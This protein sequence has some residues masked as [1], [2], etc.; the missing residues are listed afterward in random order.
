VEYVN[1]RGP[2]EWCRLRPLYVATTGKWELVTLRDSK[3][4]FPKE[5]KLYWPRS[6]LARK[7]SA[8]VVT[9][10]LNAYADADEKP[11]R[12]IVESGHP[13]P[14]FVKRGTPS[15]DVALRRSIANGSLTFPTSLPGPV[16]VRVPS[17]A[18]Q[19]IG[20]LNVE[21]EPSGDGLYHTARV[22]AEGFIDVHEMTEAGLQ[23]IEFGKHDV[24]T[25]APK[26]VIGASVDAFNI[27]SDE[28]LLDG[29]L[30]RIRKLDPRAAEGLKVTKAVFSKYLE[31]LQNADLVGDQAQSEA[32]RAHAMKLLVTQIDDRLEMA[33]TTVEALSSLPSVV[34]RT[35]IA[36]QERVEQEA[37]R[38]RHDAEIRE[39]TAL[40]R[41]VQAE[42][43]LAGL[44]QQRVVVESEATTLAATVETLKR[45]LDQLPLQFEAAM[46]N[47]A[48]TFKSDPATFLGQSIF[49]RF[50][51]KAFESTANAPR[52]STS[53]IP[54]PLRADMEL[55]TAKDLSTSC[56]MHARMLGLD[57]ET[58][59]VAATLVTNARLVL[60]TGP[61]V[62]AVLL[63][64][65]GSISGGNIL[66]FSVPSSVFGTSDIL[67]L[68]A[69]D[70]MTL[71]PIGVRLGTALQN[72]GR[73]SFL[74]V[75]SGA[76]RAPLELTLADLA[77][78]SFSTIEAADIR[79]GIVAT[80]APGPSTFRIPRS[81]RPYLAVVHCNWESA[82]RISTGSRH[83][84]SRPGRDFS[85][86]RPLESAHSK[87]LGTATERGIEPRTAAIEMASLSSVLDDPTRGPALWMIAR[88]S[89]LLNAPDLFQLIEQECGTEVAKQVAPRTLLQTL[90]A[91]MQAE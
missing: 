46:R 80:M 2:T 1:D 30:K 60:L 32:A 35:E 65:A 68:E 75:L 29:A 21:S 33:V 38:I 23:L 85:Y 63:A 74:N 19:W 58:V 82:S 77:H 47:A 24:M 22:T 25:L 40:D 44:Q 67:G 27:Q 36:I 3:A 72:G 61:A 83:I 69:I 90:D 51:V 28:H 26:R 17:S 39:S 34:A 16:Y 50:L 55:S 56:A 79:F 10:M 78:R 84:T 15:N 5:G 14:I 49:A 20:P 86:P 31:A 18:S 81:L 88:L 48:N 42:A 11:D 62:E 8:W 64:V 91:L 71:A 87:L 4:R 53:V 9:Y 89:G 7:G 66:R 57:R 70:P 43:E 76:D 73:N 54:Q 45:D 37:Q 59:I 52:L 12:F 13:L 6:K 41:A